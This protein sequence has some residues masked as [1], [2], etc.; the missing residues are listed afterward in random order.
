MDNQ[1]QNTDEI[2]ELYNLRIEISEKSGLIIGKHKIGDYFEVIG[3]DIFLPDGQGFSM[4][5]IA[6]LLPLL[7]AK[8]RINNPIDWM[9]TDDFIADPDPN[10]KALYRII[11]TGKT[12]FKRSETT[13]IP[14]SAINYELSNSNHEGCS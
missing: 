3:E 12:V 11:R 9:M 7:P 8:Q 10:C 13:L 1:S 5:A 14:I 6:A 4:Y 2:F